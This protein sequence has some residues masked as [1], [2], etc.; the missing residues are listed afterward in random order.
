MSFRGENAAGK[1]DKNR[2]QD[3]KSIKAYDG[4]TKLWENLKKKKE[5][6]ENE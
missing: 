1:G 2:L 6:S 4:N 5:K 3:K